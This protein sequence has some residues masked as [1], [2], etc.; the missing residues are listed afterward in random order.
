MNHVRA[1]RTA[2]SRPCGSGVRVPAASSGRAASGTGRDYPRPR[3]RRAPE[4][5]RGPAG[6]PRRERRPGERSTGEAHHVKN[7]RIVLAARPDGE[8]ADGDFRMESSS[9]PPL[10][11]GELLLRTIYLSLDPYMRGRMNAARS[12]VDPVELG[13]VMVGATVSE[14]VESADDAFAPGDVVLA[15]SG[16]QE[17]AVAAASRVRR[18]D[19]A[20]APITTALGVL[21]MPG[22]TAYAG[23][24][25]IGKPERG[26]TLVVAAATG[27]V[28]ATVGQ[29]ASAL[30]ARTVGIV[31]GAAKEAVAR[32][33]GFDAVIDR[34]AGE[35]GDALDAAA[36]DGIDVYFENVGGAVWD[37]VLPRL[38]TYAR[39]PVCG[40]VATYNGPAAT[41]GPAPAPALMRTV[42]TRSLTI[43]GF[44]QDEFRE[45]LTTSFTA[46]MTAWVRD[47]RVTYLEDITPGLAT[48]PRVFRG[49]L[50]GENLG[51]TIIQVGEDPTVRDRGARG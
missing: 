10:E 28:G 50:R 25:A 30:G 4:G 44:I 2:A 40:L 26:E 32:R 22:F 11:R 49:M 47:G 15:A 46:D 27:P 42:L 34:T 21:G 13:A 9:T 39:V 33:F 24:T 35:L 20:A 51:K 38:N 23:V 8:P 37:A 7:S 3:P 31:G 19:P 36:P 29:I 5:E 45:S 16:W 1:R 41:S 6:R 43:R 12:Y 18:L 48:A 14:V 17:F